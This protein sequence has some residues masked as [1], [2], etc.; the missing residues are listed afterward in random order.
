MTKLQNFCNK[1]QKLKLK[2]GSK[3]QTLPKFKNQNSDKT[4]TQ[5]LTSEN[6]KCDKTKKSN[7]G[8]LFC[9]VNFGEVDIFDK[10]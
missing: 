3:A 9:I 2:Q 8:S 1:T 5:M 6:L 7:S 4:Q 10:S